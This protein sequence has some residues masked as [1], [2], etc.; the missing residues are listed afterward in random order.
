M[1]VSVWPTLGKK[2]MGRFVISKKENEA[3]QFTLLDYENNEI[4]FSKDYST[5]FSCDEG[6]ELVRKYARI[7]PLFERGK[8]SDNKFYFYL[9]SPGG[10][11]VGASRKYDSIKSMEMGINSVRINSTDATKE[12]GYNVLVTQ[13]INYTV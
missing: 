1:L 13:P 3:F 9:K 6:I 10:K 12:L 5:K 4:L 2:V 8:S 7:D 11:I